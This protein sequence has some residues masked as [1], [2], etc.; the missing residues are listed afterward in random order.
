MMKLKKIYIQKNPKQKITI[1]R[2]RINMK[3]KINKLEDI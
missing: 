2:M 1:K 3:I